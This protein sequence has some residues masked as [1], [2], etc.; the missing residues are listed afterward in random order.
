MTWL[1][2]IRNE[3]G[4]TQEE[5]AQIVGINRASLSKLENGNTN[6][7]VRLAQKLG[8]TLGFDWTR[9]YEPEKEAEEEPIK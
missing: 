1:Q 8:S 6:P 4:L 3:K 5:V 7:S 9:F 2:E